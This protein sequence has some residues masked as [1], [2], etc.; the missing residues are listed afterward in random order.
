[1]NVREIT[2][3]VQNSSLSTPDR[4]KTIQVPRGLDKSDRKNF[5]WAPGKRKHKRGSQGSIKERVYHKGS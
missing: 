5:R 3:V 4:R 2:I 1:M